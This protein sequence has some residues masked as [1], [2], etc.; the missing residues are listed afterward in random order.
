M[1]FDIKISTVSQIN[2]LKDN[3]AHVLF[4]NDTENLND[5]I[6]KHKLL[7]SEPQK[8]QLR[9]EKISEIKLNPRNKFIDMFF[10]DLDNA[11]KGLF[12]GKFVGIKSIL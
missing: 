9:D 10:D 1:I 11:I 2:N 5:F 7:I 8:D 3:S 6:K 4:I 12:S